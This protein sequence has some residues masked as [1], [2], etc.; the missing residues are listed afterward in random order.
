MS[1]VIL[2][3]IKFNIGRLV[4]TRGAEKTLNREDM[5][6]ALKR[7]MAGDWGELDEEDWQANDDAIVL[8]H[9]LFSVYF[10]RCRAKFW[11]LTEADR[12]STTILLPEEY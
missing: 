1:Q 6:D 10:D 8:G 4:M 7:H 3:P 12:R 9:R 2:I 11:I 5:F